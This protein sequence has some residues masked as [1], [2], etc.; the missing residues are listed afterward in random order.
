[1]I[2]RFRNYHCAGRRDWRKPYEPYPESQAGI[3]VT[4]HPPDKLL[5]L[6][7]PVVFRYVF[8]MTETEQTI[9]QELLGM[10]EALAT[11]QSANP[12]PNLVAIFQRIDSLTAQLPKNGDAELL[13]FLHKK[14]Y[15]K[16]RLHLQDRSSENARGTGR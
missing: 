15:E 7:N 6:D 9:L 2:P 16:A 1:M 11:M 13:H 12:K 4:D 3:W 10:E 14:S 8:A 5:R